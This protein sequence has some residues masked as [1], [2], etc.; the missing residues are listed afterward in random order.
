MTEFITLLVCS[1]LLDIPMLF[2]STVGPLLYHFAD[3]AGEA[4]L[5]I[6]WTT[7]VSLITQIGFVIE[8]SA[9]HGRRMYQ[10]AILTENRVSAFQW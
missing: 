5:E 7:I 2:S 6:N 1:D 10:N 9:C 8:V 3:M 4:S